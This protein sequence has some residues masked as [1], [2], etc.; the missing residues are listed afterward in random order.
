MLD[1]DSLVVDEIMS[2]AAVLCMEHE[3][4]T[5]VAGMKVKVRLLRELSE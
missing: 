2:T 3:R 5:F 1:V 4:A